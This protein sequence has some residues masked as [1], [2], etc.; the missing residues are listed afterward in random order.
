VNPGHYDAVVG[1]FGDHGIE[2][3]V[4]LRTLSFDLAYTPVLQGRAAVIIGESAGSPART[5]SNSPE[6]PNAAGRY[7]SSQ[8]SDAREP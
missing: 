6:P 3:R 7:L 5:K 1:L 4:L 2:P 8:M